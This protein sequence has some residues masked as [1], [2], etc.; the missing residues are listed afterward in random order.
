MANI[1]TNKNSTVLR[2]L[3]SFWTRFF[4]D[5][6]F[7]EKFY[8]AT[9]QLLGQVYLELMET[10][11]ANSIKDVPIYS[12]K[13]WK[14][15]TFTSTDS[16]VVDITY[17]FPL[18]S[19]IKKMRFIYNKIFEPSTILEE[20]KD[21]Y[22]SDSYIYFYKN[23]FDPLDYKGITK[24][25]DGNVTTISLWAPEADV[26]VEYIYEHYG[27]LLNVYEPSSEQYKA[28][29]RGLW[30]YYMNGP[31]INRI[32]SALNIVGGYPVAT[33]DGEIVLS[34]NELTT[35]TYV[36]TTV[37]TYQFPPYTPLTVSVGQTLSAFQALTS[38]YK[39]VDYIE[40][41][42]WYDHIIV[43]QEVIP[44]L[45]TAQRMTNVDDDNP[46]FIGYPIFIGDPRWRIGMG[47][48]PNYMWLLFNQLLKYNIFYVSYNALATRFVHSKEDIVNLV[49]S[50]KPS[51]TLAV[52]EPYLYLSDSQ[53]STETFEMRLDQWLSDS[54]GTTTET[55]FI[56]MVNALPSDSISAPTDNI[57]SIE[58][59][60]SIVDQVNSVVE[61]FKQE[62]EFSLDDTLSHPSE[63][64]SIQA[65]LNTEDSLTHGIDNVLYELENTLEEGISVLETFSALRQ[66]SFY[67]TSSASEILYLDITL[68]L[69]DSFVGSR[70]DFTDVRTQIGY[71]VIGDIDARIAADVPVL[72]GTDTLGDPREHLMTEFPVDIQVV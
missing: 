24:R 43:P 18:D 23:I 37:T 11:L 53:G 9:D 2:G 54:M 61:V 39:I 32:A 41:P 58:A 47:G 68:Y 6:Q 63:Y 42:S 70:I 65:I 15:L 60:N 20:N 72:I 14:L 57:I 29:I 67:D 44:S 40:D 52:I 38:A 36:K 33:E 49:I 55:M 17:R 69:S 25:R 59:I 71:S 19:S 12:R 26:D 31:T 21:Y 1:G 28:F 46:I 22:I 16:E 4:N 48:L 51:Y 56:Q 7:L 5:K 35:G 10:L 64:Y 27:R 50:G 8:D 30:F 45:S 3:S 13:F 34:I 62:L 66:F